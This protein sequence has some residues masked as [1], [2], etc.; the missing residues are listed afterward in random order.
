MCIY[1]HCLFL[2][3]GKHNLPG[4]PSICWHTQWTYI[5]AFWCLHPKWMIFFTISVSGKSHQTNIKLINCRADTK[6]KCLL[7]SKVHDSMKEN[8]RSPVHIWE[9]IFLTH[10]SFCIPGVKVSCRSVFVNIIHGYRKHVPNLL[11]IWNHL[12]QPIQ[13]ASK[14]IWKIT[15]I[16]D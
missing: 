6:Q 9:Y 1:C 5:P 2:Y 8:F 11:V 12:F 16:L 14:I 10:W 13:E 4:I 7:S 3:Y 15:K